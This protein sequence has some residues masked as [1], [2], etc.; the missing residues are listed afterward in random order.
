MS[1]ED[2]DYDSHFM[3]EANDGSFYHFDAEDVYIVIEDFEEKYPNLKIKSIY[4][5]VYTA[6]E[7]EKVLEPHITE[8]DEW[9]SYDP[10]C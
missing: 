6:S 2:A 1:W 9:Q 10:D 8:Y 3:V 4:R 7:D 5:E